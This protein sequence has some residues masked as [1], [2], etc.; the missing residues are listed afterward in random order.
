VAEEKKPEG[1]SGVFDRKIV[2]GIAILVSFVWAVSFIFDIV[3][4]GYDPSPFIHLAMM[5]VVGAA[6]GHGFISQKDE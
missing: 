6:V 5:T 4:P 2:N 1:N 3:L